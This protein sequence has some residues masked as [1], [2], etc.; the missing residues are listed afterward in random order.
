[1]RVLI[2]SSQYHRGG[3]FPR[4][5]AQLATGLRDRG[6]DVS[7]LTRRREVDPNRDAG[8]T[9]LDYAVPERSMLMTMIRE[10]PI[11]T[12]RLNEIAS[13]YDAVLSIGLPVLTP[14]VLFGTGT[15][16]GYFR[17]NLSSL[18]PTSW[19][20]WFERLRPFHR[21]V[22]FWERRMLRGGHAAEVVVGAEAFR[23]EYLDLFGLDP[24]RVHVVPLAVEADEFRFDAGV[25]ASTRASLGIDDDTYVL[26]NVGGRGRQKGLDV[27]VDALTRLPRDRQWCAVLAGDGSTS[28]SIQAA[29]EALRADGRV[30]LL[31]RVPDVRALYCAADL[32]VFPSR[33]AP[34]D[35]VVT[36]ALATGLPAL[37]SSKAG[38]STAVR[39]GQT[40]YVIDDPNDADEVARRIVQ[41]WDAASG[42]ADRDAVASSIARYSVERQAEDVEQVLSARVQPPG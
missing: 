12:R 22:M 40:G 36:E 18:R 6:H 15:H 38:A 39:P 1:M 9:F 42:P 11:V 31:G 13:D 28:G 7:V 3:G 33:Y 4:Y 19:R 21:I 34:W 16:R 10:T 17:E 32:G 26:A 2:V 27:L 8:L 25:R 23:Q 24:Q 29:T 5:A 20:W 37:A 30:Q 14:V 41:W 35:L